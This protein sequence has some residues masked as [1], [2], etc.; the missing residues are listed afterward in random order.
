[1]SYDL[2]VIG[3]GSGGIAAARRAAKHGARV[4]LVESGRLGGTCVNVGCVPKKIMWHASQIAESLQEAAAYGFGRADAVTHDWHTLRSNRDAYVEWLNGIYRRNLLASGAELIEGHAQ[5][6]G[7]REV[8]A[9]ERTLSAKHILIA[10][11]GRPF[12]PKCE[13]ADL[14]IDSDGFFALD[15][16]P[17]SVIVAGSGYIAVELAGMLR[18]LGAKVTL[19]ARGKR[20]LRTFDAMLSTHLEGEMRAQDI[21]LVLDEPIDSLRRDGAHVTAKLASGSTRTADA[22]IWAVGRTPNIESLA[23]DRAGVAT[24]ELGAI[25]VDAF[26]NTSAAN[27]YAVGDVTGRMMLTPVAIAAARRLADRLFGGQPERKLDYEMIPTVVFSHP[28]IGTVGLTEAQ[29]REKFGDAVKVYE[30]RFKA[31]YYGIQHRKVGSAMK[32]VCVGADERIVGLH[33]IGM[34]SD[35]M[36]QGFA[37]ALRMGATKRDFDDT[38]AIHPT[39]AEEMVTMN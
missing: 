27:V 24:D 18:A 6:A 12:H 22:L 13:G 28:T 34:G 25:R 32:L 36:L 5:F 7:P 35:E 21:E 20:L 26:Q 33:T 23:L 11:G 16:R 10:T 2:L 19:I 15:R 30:S 3:G 31:L 37:V 1:M 29:A 8:V 39:S 14:G 4:A 17:E 9:G 38:V